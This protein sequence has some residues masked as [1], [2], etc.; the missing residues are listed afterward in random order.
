MNN[1]LSNRVL[2]RAYATVIEGFAPRS[3]G[4]CAL[5]VQYNTLQFRTIQFVRSWLIHSDR[6]RDGDHRAVMSRRN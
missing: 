5:A 2:L 3:T 4:P 6:E 1:E